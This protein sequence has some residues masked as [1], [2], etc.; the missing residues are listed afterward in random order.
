MY[1]SAEQLAVANRAVQET[2]EQTSVAWQAI[3]HWDTGDPGQ[4]YVRDDVIDTPGFLE[5]K[6]YREEFDLTLAQT[7]APTPDSLLAEVMDKTAKL[8]AQVDDVVIKAVLDKVK[9]LDPDL[10]GAKDYELL[11]ALIDARASVEDRGYRAPSCL[12][13]N[14]TGLKF[15]GQ[16]QGGFPITDA[17]LTTAN[18]NSF[19]RSSKFEEDKD[20]KKKAIRILFLGRR[21]LIPHGCASEA[22]PG[23]EPVD[24]AVS[25]LPSL[26]IIGE[27]QDG[28]IKLAVRI[29]FATRVKDEYG[30]VR[31]LYEIP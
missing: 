9:P 13:T 11:D 3:P 16:L 20:P 25:V 8:A 27:N 24:L 28:T 30:G 14:T 21:Q 2:F 1:L 10:A 18:V 7:S 15:L 29:R 12:I 23:E 31:A 6:P 4:T 5:L 17:L 22:S 26:E 19:Q